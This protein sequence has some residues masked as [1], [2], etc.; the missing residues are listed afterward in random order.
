MLTVCSLQVY[1]KQK[2]SSW[3]V[4]ALLNHSCI[5]LFLDIYNCRVRLAIKSDFRCEVFIYKKPCAEK[6]PHEPLPP[7]PD[8]LQNPKNFYIYFCIYKQQNFVR[9]F[10]SLLSVSVWKTKIRT[11]PFT[12][13]FQEKITLPFLFLTSER[14]RYKSK[15][16]G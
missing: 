14:E 2:L 10:L 7:P 9:T 15:H 11:Y 13:T 16:I 8:T 1:L 4:G 3:G 5:Y 12:C 6:Y